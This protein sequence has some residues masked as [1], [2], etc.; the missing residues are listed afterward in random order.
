MSKKIVM[1]SI[2][3]TFPVPKKTLT[4]AIGMAFI[5]SS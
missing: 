1:I 2:K 3:L 4:K 5:A